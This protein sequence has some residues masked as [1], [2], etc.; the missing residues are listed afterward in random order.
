MF[1]VNDTIV[2]G[3]EGV[4]RIIGIE[5][6]DFVGVKKNYYVIKPEGSA[7]S[8]IYVPFDSEA[9]VAKMSK[10]LS[11]EEINALIDSLSDMPVEWIPNERERK[12]V[13]KSIF[14]E[15]DR[16][17]LLNMIR[18][19]HIER[20]KRE[21]VGKRLHMTDEHFLKDAEQCIYSEFQHVLNIKREDVIPYIVSRIEKNV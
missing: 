15:G 20:K 19:I 11:K 17:E 8:I 9:L 4:C 1:K 10:L 6:K 21:A 13:Y 7:A 14:A 2:Y 12:E 18:A 16:A 3:S 5:E